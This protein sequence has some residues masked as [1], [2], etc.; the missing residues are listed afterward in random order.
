MQFFLTFFTKLTSSVSRSLKLGHGSTWPGQIALNLNPG[1]IKDI[2]K[3]SDCKIIIIAGTNG[4]TTTAKMLETIL[5]SSGQRTFHNESGANLLNG[6]AAS[7]ILNTSPSGK[8]NMDYGV[9]EVDEASLPLVLD[10]LTPDYLILLNLF[11]DQLDRYG[12]I[13][14]LTEKWRQALNKLGSKTTLILNADD[15]QIAYFDEFTKTKSKF[16]GLDETSKTEKSDAA[17]STY[18]PRCQ[19][20]LLF[21]GKIFSHLGHWKCQK[22]GLVRPKTDLATLSRYPLAGTYNKYNTLAAVLTATELG[23]SQEDS[24]LYLQDFKP[25][26]GRQEEITFRGRKVKLFLSKNP[27]SFNQSL[28]TI[29]EEKP[30]SLLFVLN[31]RIPDGRDVSW[32]WDT[33]IEN[34]DFKNTSLFASGDRVYDM[35][36]RLKY[37]T[38]QNTKAYEGLNNA[39][40]AA[41]RPLEDNQTL[42]VL[43]TYSA[44]LEVRNLLQ[45]KKIL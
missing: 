30:A 11:R 36:V 22:C 31:D 26:F 24:L 28:A 13:N 32:I 34:Y 6:I 19:T 18:C 41:L 17:D 8:L 29:M 7:I 23:I 27:T 40:L 21:S 15:P 39:L 12:E 35:A 45:G 2:L 16:F 20:K 25:A 5:N 14:I 9:F 38:N 37:A 43:P 44:M 4:K 1:I 10:E 42:Y 3:N 33:E